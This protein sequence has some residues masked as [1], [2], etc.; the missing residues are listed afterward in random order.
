MQ[1]GS[2]APEVGPGAA[3]AGP[4][5]GG[6]ALPAA[7]AA[8]AGA[9]WAALRPGGTRPP[10]LGAARAVASQ[11]HGSMP[12]A[13]GGGP[14]YPTQAPPSSSWQPWQA[15]HPA[16]EQA[17]A[18]WA[19]YLCSRAGDAGPWRGRGEGWRGYFVGGCYLACL[20]CLLGDLCLVGISS[21][22]DGRCPGWPG[23][24]TRYTRAHCAPLPMPRSLVGLGRPPPCAVAALCH[25]ALQLRCRPQPPCLL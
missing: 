20:D 9:P 19:A 15:P 5:V 3:P 17:A 24:G 4:C 7:A 23:G 16:G 21:L 8:A 1:T 22:L 13:A 12:C 14:P 6:A 25:S 18:A 10:A 2:R 11:F